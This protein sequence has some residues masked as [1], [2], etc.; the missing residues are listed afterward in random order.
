M[1]SV[2]SRKNWKD[3]FKEA[4]ISKDALSLAAWTNSIGYNRTLGIDGAIPIHL[5]TDDDGSVTYRFE[6]N[7]SSIL[8]RVHKN[9]ASDTT[10]RM[11]I[12]RQ[13]D[14]LLHNWQM[15]SARNLLWLDDAFD[16]V[17]EKITDFLGEQKID[18]IKDWCNLYYTATQL[19][20]KYYKSPVNKLLKGGASLSAKQCAILASVIGASNL[21][22]FENLALRI[23]DSNTY[24]NEKAALIGIWEPLACSVGK[25]D[26]DAPEALRKYIKA[27]L[28]K[29]K[30][31]VLKKPIKIL[32]LFKDD[33]VNKYVIDILSDDL[34]N[35]EGKA[36]IRSAFPDVHYEEKPRSLV[37]NVQRNI[38]Y[39]TNCLI[40]GDVAKF[41]CQG[42]TSKRKA[43]Q[44]IGIAIWALK[45][46]FEEIFGINKAGSDVANNSLLITYNKDA[47]F[48]NSSEDISI[49]FTSD[50][51][52]LVKRAEN[53]L[54]L[55]LN[56]FEFMVRRIDSDF[57]K[58]DGPHS[59][60]M[61][62]FNLSKDL[63]NIL[64]ALASRE[65]IVN[66]EMVNGR[67]SVKRLK[68]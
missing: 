66:G 52:N 51:E 18:P 38:I 7:L 10:L 4:V 47:S 9:S 23:I 16:Q 44:M 59:E 61:T 35:I 43:P 37:R 3:F 54:N 28:N 50:D 13:A 34:I 63:E 20:G 25:S 68:I 49:T 33:A 67:D 56:N 5:E 24:P 62:A 8:F 2:L 32:K 11:E 57:D 48:A 17:V 64:T 41:V 30:L 1:S 65:I 42:V 46:Y 12:K 14:N 40:N 22:S 58:N 36:I 39:K 19:T 55:F 53:D 6:L 26:R 31:S 29:N 27:N 21:N 15:K 60:R 45:F